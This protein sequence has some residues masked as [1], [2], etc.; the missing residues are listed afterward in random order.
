MDTITALWGWII[1]M[2]NSAVGVIHELIEIQPFCSN[3]LEACMCARM[4]SSIH[5]S[6]WCDICEH[7]TPRREKDIRAGSVQ[8][9]KIPERYLNRLGA[10][11]CVCM[12][13]GIAAGVTESVCYMRV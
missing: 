13:D 12:Q 5:V 1:I 9:R 2:S 10:R 4:T 7:E 11:A 6:E 3:R 8:C